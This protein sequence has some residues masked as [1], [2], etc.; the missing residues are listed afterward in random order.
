MVNFQQHLE[1]QNKK[2][3]KT[4]GALKFNQDFG[5]GRSDGRKAGCDDCEENQTLRKEHKDF[6]RQSNIE[7][8]KLVA[9]RLSPFT[10]HYI[11]CHYSQRYKSEIGEE[12]SKCTC[13]LDDILTELTKAIE[14][15]EPR[16]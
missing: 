6:L 7:T 2:F 3:D 16:E 14:S 4:F 1:E 9:N 5:S 15:D 10:S 11:R 8:I 13:G 12:T